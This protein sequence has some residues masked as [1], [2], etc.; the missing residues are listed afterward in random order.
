MTTV[1]TKPNRRKGLRAMPETS[2]KTFDDMPSKNQM[3]VLFDYQREQTGT[4]NNIHKTLIGDGNGE[5]GL[6]TQT[7][8]NK[9]S[10][11]KV[12]KV[13]LILFPGTLTVIGIFVGVLKL[14]G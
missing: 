4:L 7:A 8:L 11:S 10:I 13:V 12:W 2:K 9:A 3:S 5:E 1:I 14:W 6:V